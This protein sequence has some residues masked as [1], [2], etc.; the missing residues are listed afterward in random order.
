MHRIPLISSLVIAAAF[1]TGCMVQPR[2]GPAAPAA[3]V[4]GEAPPPADVAPAATGLTPMGALVCGGNETLAY[5]NVS[6]EGDA[7]ALVA[8]GNCSVTITNSRIVAQGTAIELGG[9]ATVRLENSQV[10]GQAAIE[11]SGNATLEAVGNQFQ[12]QRAF[13]GNA[14]IAIDQ[15]NTWH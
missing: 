6:I 14:S 3:P 10:Q 1:A 12:G 2:P 13:G 4:Y 11:A 5:S 8:D 15:D 9:N 7:V